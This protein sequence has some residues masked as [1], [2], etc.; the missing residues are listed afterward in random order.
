M[1]LIKVVLVGLLLSLGSGAIIAT[2]A[3]QKVKK[4]V[5]QYKESQVIDK[6]KATSHVIAMDS[7]V[8]GPGG[9]SATSIG[10]H[11][12]LT[13]SHCERPDGFVTVDGEKNIPIVKVLRD[14]DDHS[15]LFL[16]TKAVRFP[17]TAKFVYRPLRTGEFV[18]IWGNPGDTGVQFVSVLRTGKYVAENVFKGRIT[19]VFDLAAQHGDSGSAIFDI[20]GN[21]VDVLSIGGSLSIPNYGDVDNATGSMRVTFPPSV[22]EEAAKF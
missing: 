4:V 19:D 18:F 16:D 17:Y 5:V 3:P 20:N 21:I 14:G 2:D 6:V 11:A 8:T 10:P 7:P 12:L 22:F 13:A 15:I 1:K 9:C